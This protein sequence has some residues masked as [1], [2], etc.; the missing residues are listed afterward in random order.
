MWVT[1]GGAQFLETI[2]IEEEEKITY[3]AHSFKAPQSIAM[4]AK[5]K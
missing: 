3:P 5:R 4:H 1:K 2:I